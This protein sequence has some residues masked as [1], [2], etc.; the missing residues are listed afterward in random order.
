MDSDLIE[1]SEHT[2]LE[3]TLHH[4]LT[5]DTET[6]VEVDTEQRSAAIT[7]DHNESGDDD[8]HRSDETAKC[9]DIGLFDSDI[10]EGKHLT[11]ESIL[12]DDDGMLF[13]LDDTSKKRLISEINIDE[14]H[15][16]IHKKRRLESTPY[17]QL[18]SPASLS[19]L[20]AD[21]NSNGSSIFSK[22]ND[23]KSPLAAV[24][25]KKDFTA[26]QIKEI[27]KRIINTHKLML[28]FNFLKDSYSK[29]CVEFKKVLNILKE[30]EIHR[31][32]LLKENEDLR[33]KLNGFSNNSK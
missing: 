32:H 17:E 21:D 10:I 33:L 2:D 7:E 15:T 24:S 31:S 30:S 20:S 3:K 1:V 18:L 14:K 6:G 23:S 13:D 5:T 29:T 19:P 12:D 11:L 26:E 8:Q 4:L 28:N 22:I 16:N 27:K 9:I 25:G